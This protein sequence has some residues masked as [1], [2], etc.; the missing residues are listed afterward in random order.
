M[1]KKLK[2]GLI[3]CGIWGK[4]IL[5]DLI[6]LKT[7]VY[8]YETDKKESEDVLRL[9]ASKYFT[10][11]EELNLLD[12]IIISTPA[13]THAN[14]LSTLKDLDKPIFVEKPLCTSSNDLETIK[15]LSEKDIYL[16][17]V[18][19]YHPGIIKL[20]E[21]TKSKE[22]GELVQLKT[23][24]TNW[25]SPR[26]DTDSVWTLVPHDITIVLEILGYIPEP[27]FAT[28]EI[29]NG[30]PKGMIGVLGASNEF[31]FEVS[32]RYFDK[33]REVRAHFEKGVAVL[34]DEKVDF[35]EIYNGD[36]KSIS[37]DVEIEKRKFGSSLPLK[38]EL[39]AFIDYVNG[40]ASPKSNLQEG[41]D[42]IESVLKLRKLAEL[43]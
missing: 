24:R 18:W 21:I 3:G 39:L 12:G 35:I 32:N 9:G 2:I 33:R 19:R 14:I 8:V 6:S 4:N 31:I 26:F 5:R 25:T 38:K 43:N 36:E 17:H 15:Q 30:E 7:E 37:S 13:T 27:S 22:L 42:I 16:M 1:S 20:G 10:E 23:T 41:I 40:G 34:K 28:C 11:L 29:Y